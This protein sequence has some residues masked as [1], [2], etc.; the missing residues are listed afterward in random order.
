MNLFCFVLTQTSSP[1]G[2][3]GAPIAVPNQPDPSQ[4]FIDLPHYINSFWD[5]IVNISWIEAIV[6]IAFSLVYLIYGWRVFRL[7][8]TINFMAIGLALGV[9]AGEKLG[10]PLWG[11]IIGSIVLA[12]VTYPF[13]KY[14]VSILGAL[15]GAFL[16]ACLWRTGQLPDA[17][18]W[19]GALGGLI[20]GGFMAFTSFKHSIMMFSALQGAVFLSIGAMALLNDFPNLSGHLAKIVFT[21]VSIL[22]LT[23]ILPTA[24]GILYQQKLIKQEK[25]WSI[26]E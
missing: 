1:V 5:M 23:F 8:V 19:C 15:A 26:P 3:D 9:A 13:M 17:I 11:G 18:I 16:G 12:V 6:C 22:P 21:N 24:M 25:N 14:C 7:L 10:S 2:P 20:A 4:Y